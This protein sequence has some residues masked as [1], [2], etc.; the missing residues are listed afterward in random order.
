MHKLKEKL[1]EQLMEFEDRI[2]KNPSMRISGSDIQAVHMI[3]GSLK[4]L[5]KIEMYEEYEGGESQSGDMSY[6]EDTSYRR[7]RMR[8]KRDSMGRYSRDSGYSEDGYSERG[9]Y[10]GNG[11]YSYGSSKEEMLSKIDEMKREIEKM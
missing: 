1:K 11:S 4:N 10:R 6:D 7:G 8:A 9:T 3:S 5:C 2:K